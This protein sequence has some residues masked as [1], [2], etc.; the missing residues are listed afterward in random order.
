MYN[1]IF[2]LSNISDIAQVALQAVNKIIVL[3]CA[4]HHGVFKFVI[5]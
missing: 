1:P 2:G 4:I 3:A 5:M